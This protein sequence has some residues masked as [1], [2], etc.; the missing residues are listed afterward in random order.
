MSLA[1]WSGISTASAAAG[2]ATFKGAWFLAVVISSQTSSRR[3]CLRS[4]ELLW[5]ALP[6][7]LYRTLPNTRQALGKH[8][9]SSQQMAQYAANRCCERHVQ[10]LVAIASSPSKSSRAA[11]SGERPGGIKASTNSKLSSSLLIERQSCQRLT[12]AR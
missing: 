1:I 12:S 7:V 8:Y 11:L 3:R 6:D 4:S 9:H 5:N 2:C 10:N